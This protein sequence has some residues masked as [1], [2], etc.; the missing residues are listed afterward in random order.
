MRPTS[1]LAPPDDVPGSVVPE[2]EAP[3]S[4][5]AP[6]ELDVGLPPVAEVPPPPI[7]P[8][9][10]PTMA[11]QPVVIKARYPAATAKVNFVFVFIAVLSGWTALRV[12]PDPSVVA[13]KRQNL[14]IKVAPPAC[15]PTSGAAPM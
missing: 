2:D 5:A 12:E 13:K 6:P 7:C 1:L 3:A 8:G 10:D 15:G 11:S 14:K 4:P 9:S